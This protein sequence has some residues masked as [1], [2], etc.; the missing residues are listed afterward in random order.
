MGFDTIIISLLIIHALFL[1]RRGSKN[2]SSNGEEEDSFNDEDEYFSREEGGFGLLKE[3]PLQ[4]DFAEVHSEEEKEQENEYP[5]Y[6]EYPQ[7]SGR[8]WVMYGPN[9]EWE[10]IDV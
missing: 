8:H 7:G 9:L 10:L 1:H 6:Q 3:E 2:A 5:M 4:Q